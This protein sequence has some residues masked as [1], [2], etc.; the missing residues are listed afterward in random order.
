MDSRGK[1]MHLH[2]SLFD[3]RH[4]GFGGFGGYPGAPDAPIIPD[5]GSDSGSPAQGDG[6]GAT[7]T[8]S[9]GSDSGPTGS[10]GSGPTSTTGVGGGAQQT[11]SGSS[12][13]QITSTP[14]TG[15]PNGSG[16]DGS[17][18]G[19]GSGSG[20]GGTGGASGGSSSSGGSDSRSGL[21]PG[22][23]AGLV[24]GLLALLAILGF[25]LWK[26]RKSPFVQRILAPFSKLNFQPI[27]APFAKL[28][29]MGAAATKANPR[30]S[31]G[32]T[33]LAAGAIAGAGNRTPSPQPPMAEKSAGGAS[34]TANPR[35]LTPSPTDQMF[36]VTPASAL[37]GG[38]LSPTAAVATTSAAATR[39]T[40]STS[41]DSKPLPPP[42][43][44][45]LRV[46]TMTHLSH[47]TIGS[48]LSSTV[49]SPTSMTWP[50]PPIS[51]PVSAP[52]S[53]P[54]TATSPRSPQHH[55]QD[56]SLSS[57]QWISME[58]PGQTVVR[59]NNPRRPA[60]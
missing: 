54:T 3:K 22:A 59:I 39:A 2:A 7:S 26:F 35:I 36:A 56:P 4:G 58:Q 51:P 8:S 47:T 23:T 18:S 38:Y 25:L 12:S 28:G 6:S 46:S 37:S 17:G 27:L 20:P 60:S 15:S 41:L 31:M 29:G 11:G 10:L 30:D 13:P 19:S 16:P 1:K 33:L 32:N 45:E 55:R 14:G 24:L 9:S 34:A 48:S 52:M 44:E 42:P 53:P 57:S 5:T 50:M 21:S 49:L 40:S 43:P